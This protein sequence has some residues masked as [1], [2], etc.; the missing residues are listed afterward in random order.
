MDLELSRVESSGIKP[1]RLA[2]IELTTG[3]GEAV[4]VVQRSAD[5]LHLET[6]ATID[7]RSCPGRTLPVRNRSTAQLL[8]REMEILGRDT[9]YEDALRLAS[10]IE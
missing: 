2:K 6:H 3:V 7:G 1:G 8:S 4:F 5:G 10:S 9:T